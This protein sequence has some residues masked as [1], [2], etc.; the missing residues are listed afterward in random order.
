MRNLESLDTTP[1]V[2]TMVMLRTAMEEYLQMVNCSR[3][4]ATT[5]LGT[6]T[7]SVRSSHRHS[8]MTA[9]M[10]WIRTCVRPDYEWSNNV[11]ISKRSEDY[12]RTIRV[13]WKKH[14]GVAPMQLLPFDNDVEDGGAMTLQ[15]V[16]R[17]FY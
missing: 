6:P 1:H 14:G 7:I 11:F 15:P 2:C 16:P 17:W 10:T 13:V 12:A 4:W 5:V 3:P 9:T 8:T